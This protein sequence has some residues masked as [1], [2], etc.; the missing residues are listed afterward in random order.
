MKKA[1][2]LLLTICVASTLVTPAFASDNLSTAE[3]NDCVQ[4]FSTEQPMPMM[5]DETSLQSYIAGKETSSASLARATWKE[6]TANYLENFYSQDIVRVKENENYITFWFDGHD[7]TVNSLSLLEEEPQSVAGQIMKVEYLKPESS[8][9]SSAMSTKI[10]YWWGWSDG[11][12]RL[13]SSSS[14]GTAF[15]VASTVAL[16]CLSGKTKTLLSIVLSAFQLNTS[17]FISRYGSTRPVKGET[18]AN[19]YYQNKIAYAYVYGS[20][21]PGCEIGSRR[22]FNGSLAGYKTNAGQ[23]IMNK[24]N[25]PKVGSPENNPTNY[26]SIEKKKHFNDNQWMINQAIKY[27]TVNDTELYADIYATVFKKL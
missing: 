26:D 20:W 27:Y 12:V 18:Y 21:L 24:W 22:G 7:N 15:N 9:S 2:S 1:I 16:T 4:R 17:E 10:E 25:Q 13:D 3:V 6:N 19:Y 11:L 5:P 23:W 8:Y 14:A